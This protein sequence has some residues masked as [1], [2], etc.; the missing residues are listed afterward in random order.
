MTFCEEVLKLTSGLR[1]TRE[2]IAR[3]AL[4]SEVMMSKLLSQIVSPL[5]R[6]RLIDPRDSR[7]LQKLRDLPGA[8]VPF[9]VSHFKF[10][11]GLI[12]LWI[13][14]RE[15]GLSAPADVAKHNYSTGP[16]GAKST[17]VLA[18]ARIGQS[19]TNGARSLRKKSEKM[20]RRTRSFLSLRDTRVSIRT[21]AIDDIERPSRATTLTSR[22]W[23]FYRRGTEKL[24]PTIH[25]S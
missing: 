16:A 12:L 23:I 11:L 19:R 21:P 2:I 9:I 5:S 8:I 7:S 1:V 20:D 25:F 22:C 13:H 14:A 18:Q 24:L 17:A 3:Y 15:F 4:T 10:P 6:K